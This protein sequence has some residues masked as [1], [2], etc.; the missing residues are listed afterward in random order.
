MMSSDGGTPGVGDL[1]S[2][3]FG[4]ATFGGSGDTSI[5]STWPGDE[6]GARGGVVRYPAD[7]QTH[8]YSVSSNAF[9]GSASQDGFPAYH[10]T[11]NHLLWRPL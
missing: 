4:N 10:E 7:T 11:Y 3:S 9:F 6:D 1:T 2:I 5:T 8:T